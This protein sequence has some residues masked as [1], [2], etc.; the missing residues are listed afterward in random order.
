M[1]PN[2]DGCKT[3]EWWT[4]VEAALPELSAVAR[5]MLCIPAT[6]VR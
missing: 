3:R 1:V 4:S 5:R 6:M 2:V